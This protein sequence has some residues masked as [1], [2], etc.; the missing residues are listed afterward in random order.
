MLEVLGKGGYGKVVR[1][2][3]K[4]TGQIY[5]LKVL[6]KAEL[7]KA[8]M[9]EQLLNEVAILET[10]DHPN[11]VRL[12]G[13][14]EDH[15]TISLVLELAEGSLYT[16]L[17]PEGLVDSPAPIPRVLRD[18]FRAV[19]YLHSRS[20]PVVHRDIKPENILCFGQTVKLADFGSSNWKT[21]ILD[22][23]MCG[24]PE[25]LAPEM[26]RRMGHDEKLDVWALGVLAF[27]L[28]FG[29]TPFSAHCGSQLLESKSQLF[30]RLTEAI[31]VLSV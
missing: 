5:A 24:T 25:Y 27:E 30:S 14:T 22:Q 9:Q 18:I 10:L 3:L 26:I 29:H 12:F 16:H 7:E 2:R 31:L 8:G 4:P 15:K 11:I 1:A 23:T 21:N 13:H 19:E 28:Y 17:R 20:P 6:E